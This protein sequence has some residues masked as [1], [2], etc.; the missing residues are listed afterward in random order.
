MKSKIIFA[1]IL[2]GFCSSLG[3]ADPEDY[4]DW[5]NHAVDRFTDAEATFNTVRT[6]LLK[7]FYDSKLTEEQL[8]EAATEGMLRSLN[9]NEKEAWNKLISPTEMKELQTDLTGK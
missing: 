9:G 5:K 4:R 8:Y 1:A 7:K 6:Q 2:V 3:H